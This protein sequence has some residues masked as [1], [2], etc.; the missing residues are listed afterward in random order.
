LPPSLLN[1]TFGNAAVLLV[2]SASGGLLQFV[3]LVIAGRA[4]GPEEFGYYG[5]LVSILMFVL[6]VTN[7]GLPSIVVRELA[8][9]PEDEARI[10]ASMFRI[11][12]SM[13]AI[14]FSGALI[15]T[16]LQPHAPSDRL[17]VAL[18]FVYLLFVPFDLAPLF[19]AHKLSR[20]DV[21]GRLSGRVA[22]VVLL[23]TLWMVKH[24]L[25]VADV[26]ACASLL[27]LVNVLV[28]WRISRRL[29]FSLHPLGSPANTRRLMRI[30]AYVMWG[31]LML[32]T[33]LYSQTILLKWLSTMLE[34][35][36]YS[37]A[38]RLLM[39]L[40][41]L[42]GILYRLLL[43]I[44]SEAAYDDAAFTA[45]LQRALPALTLIFA[46]AAVLGI[47]G[48]EVLII[49]IFGREYSGTVL[50]LQIGLSHFVVT[51]AGSLFGT[52]L[53]AAGDQRTPALGLTVGCIAG[54]G[55]SLLLIPPY[56]A[57]GAAWSAFAAAIISASVAFPVFLRRWR[58]GVGRRMVRITL[59]SLA[60]LI[61][62]YV[63]IHSVVISAIA[64]LG[65]SAVIILIGLWL[66]GEISRRKLDVLISLFKKPAQNLDP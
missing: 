59:S 39:P 17:V 8:Q 66:S 56:G 54:V 20:W 53:L 2:G 58:L 38:A 29:G 31:N 60:G 45:R 44:V 15:V 50:P 24:A 4:L 10:F 34:T 46:P 21:P 62:F 47:A 1:K 42:K 41:I 5:Y 7:W 18:I 25:T 33:Y 36:Y 6:V 19:D 14:F 13:A 65:V 52:A 55:L 12:A 23:L 16:T 40:F 9:R 35:G 61:G 64:A 3:F 26:A 57:V 49:P 22:S 37:M 27:M 43:P 48:A 32:T 51:G 11:R 28:A 63:L 30:S